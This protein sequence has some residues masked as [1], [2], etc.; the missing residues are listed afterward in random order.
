M[1]DEFYLPE[2]EVIKPQSKDNKQGRS[3]SV[4][5]ETALGVR[6]MME[7]AH[8]T[9]YD[10]YQALL[11]ERDGSKFQNDEVIFDPYDEESPLFDADF[12]GIARESARCVLPVSNYTELYWSQNL[13][14]MLALIKLRLDPHA[15][16]EIRMFAQA[17]YDI[18][19]PLFPHA[20]EAFEDYTR[21][22]SRNSRMETNLIQDLFDGG[23]EVRALWH[24]ML[25]DA[26]SDKALGLKY[27]MSIREVR[28][29]AKKWKLPIY[30]EVVPVPVDPAPIAVEAPKAIKKPRKKK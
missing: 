12:E 9:S 22:A 20:V 7:A 4:S 25:V 26:G 5:D 2:P 24:K 27:G 8:Q 1:T 13:R 17:L 19:Q 28:E 29:V 6:W 15:Q 23:S 30:V 11:G 18:L 10:V 14:N 21:L 3:G 16:Y